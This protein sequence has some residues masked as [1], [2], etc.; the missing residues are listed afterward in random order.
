MRIGVDLAGEETAEQPRL[1]LK[2]P[3]HGDAVA[4]DRMRHLLVE[5]ALIG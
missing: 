2:Q 1:H 5:A 3:A 4:E